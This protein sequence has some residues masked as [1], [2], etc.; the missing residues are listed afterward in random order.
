MAGRIIVKGTGKAT[1]KPDCVELFITLESFD[2]KYERATSIATKKIEQI[3][4]L[5]C[6]AGFEKEALKTKDF[7]VST[8]Y[9]NERDRNGN[10]KNVFKGYIVSHELM[11]SFDFDLKRLAEILSVFSNDTIYPELSINF[12]VKDKSA[13]SE[14]MLRTATKNAK[15][16]A[17]ILCDASGVKLGNLIS[18][19]YSWQDI[20]IYSET[21]HVLAEGTPNGGICFGELFPEDI[22][23]TD[24]ATFEWE[25][26][27]K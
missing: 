21:R 25:I 2:T 10:Y 18:I 26:I 20:N 8:K 6:N 12:A 7:D 22:S 4:T 19:N 5:I 16:N 23:V 3:T 17:E 24:T 1:A 9:E 15:R 14:E 27:N 11:I 13:I